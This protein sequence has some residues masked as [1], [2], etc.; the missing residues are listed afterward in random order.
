[1]T[2]LDW[3]VILVLV[4]SMVL[5]LLR[6][7]VAEIFSLA[8]W[9]VAF[10]A[11]KWGSA[12]VAPALPMGVESEGMR[13]FTAFVVVFLGA[14]IIVMLLG[15]LVKGTV[16]AAG[17]GGIDKAVG[18]VFGLLRGVAILVGLTLAAGLTALPQTGFWKNA[19]SSRVLEILA[20]QAMPLLPAK[21]VEHIHFNR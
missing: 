3:I 12:I 21:V 4:A 14:M 9:V 18:G 5:G 15:R 10:L 17:M 16:S 6:G 1:M 13:Y 2:A 11:A 7:L 20:M 19:L 8:S